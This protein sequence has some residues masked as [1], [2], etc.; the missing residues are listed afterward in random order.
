VGVPAVIVVGDVPPPRVAAT[1]PPAAPAAATIR[2]T[3]RTF[4][5]IAPPAAAAAAA[6]AATFCWWMTIL[7]SRLLNLATT[8][9]CTSPALVWYHSPRYRAP[10]IV[11][12]YGK[13]AAAIRESTAGA[14][15][16]QKECNRRS[17]D[18]LVV[19]VIHLDHGLSSHPLADIVDRSF[20]LENRNIQFRWFLFLGPDRDRPC[21]N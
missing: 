16:G 12:H 15:F 5:E 3:A 20:S 19:L 17:G 2:M 11:G 18:R 4:P 21:L 8:R 10:G 13:A 14:V 7:A 9:I 6:A 1:A